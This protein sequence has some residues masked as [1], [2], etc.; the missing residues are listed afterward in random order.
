MRRASLYE[1]SVWIVIGGAFGS[2]GKG[3]Y[4]AWLVDPKNRVN[5]NAATGLQNL[6]V[7]RSGGPQAGHS[8][9]V[10]GRVYAMRQIPCGWFND[11]AKLYIGPGALIDL[12]VLHREIDLVDAHMGANYCQEHL[13][14]DRH[15]TIVEEKHRE[16]EHDLV[17]GIGS[18]GEG[19]GAAQADKVMRRATVAKNVE[20]LQSYIG[21]VGKELRKQYRDRNTAIVVE[22]TQGWGL[23]LNGP[24]Y[25]TATSRDITPPQVLNDVG[26]TNNVN[27]VT[28]AVMRTFP[29][30]V[31]GPSGYMGEEVTWDEL[32]AQTGG[33]IQPERTTVTK[34]IRR[35][36]KWN[37]ELVEAMVEACEPDAIA[38]SFFD[39][40][41][42][43]LHNSQILDAAAEEQ[44]AKLEKDVATPI[45]YVSTGFQNWVRR[46][47]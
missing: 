40:L 17:K 32:A 46:I 5:I 19:V 29:I 37:P 25:P 42:P 10:D 11:K 24:F 15:V 7:V 26:L 28:I 43:D 12:E 1:S 38:L 18:T 4:I 14:I 22:S 16:A 41:R 20:I 45:V 30:R 34:R 6:S 3:A 33:Y 9:I 27:Y 2:E 31:A 21:D 35:I 44:I 36:A 23:S 47:E 8:I 13:M 39:Y